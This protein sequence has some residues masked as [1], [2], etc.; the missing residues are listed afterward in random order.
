MFDPYL[1]VQRH[2]HNFKSLH[3]F[4]KLES[5]PAALVLTVGGGGRFGRSGFG[6]LLSIALFTSKLVTCKINVGGRGHV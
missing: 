4:Q 5:Q 6:F 1:H 2:V 3:I